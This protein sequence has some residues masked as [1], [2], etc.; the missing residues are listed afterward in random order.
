VFII[1]FS[2]KV[3]KQFAE[4]ADSALF[5]NLVTAVLKALTDTG[6]ADT[7]KAPNGA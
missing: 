4:I 2:A 5:D 3:F 6:G 7:K 1:W